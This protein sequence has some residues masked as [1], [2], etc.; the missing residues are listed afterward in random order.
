MVLILLRIGTNGGL[1]ALDNE[2]SGY[3]KRRG[4][5]SLSQQILLS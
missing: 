5:Y 1:F 3:K 4:I 2:S